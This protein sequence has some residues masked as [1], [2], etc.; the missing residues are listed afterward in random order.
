MLFW[1]ET[2]VQLP[3]YVIY[4]IRYKRVEYF[5]TTH[6][7]SVAIAK[8]KC[9]DNDTYTK[10]IPSPGEK[11]S[12]GDRDASTTLAKETVLLHWIAADEG[13][14]SNVISN[15]LCREQLN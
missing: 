10:T 14:I 7:I 3:V 13:R 9:Q 2:S 8:K 6:K 1:H 15:V 4:N 11:A 5:N 12:R